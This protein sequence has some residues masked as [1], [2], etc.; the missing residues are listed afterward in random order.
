[1]ASAGPSYIGERV[2]QEEEDQL[3]HT[4]TEF[5]LGLLV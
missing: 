2:G 1:M 3:V 5:L 4:E